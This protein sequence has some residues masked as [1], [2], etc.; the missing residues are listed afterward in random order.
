MQISFFR[1]T[2]Y[3]HC[4]T[5]LIPKVLIFCIYIYIQLMGSW[6]LREVRSFRWQFAT[7]RLTKRTF[8]LQETPVALADLK[9]ILLLFL[10][11]YLIFLHPRIIV[12]LIGV[13]L[14]LWHWQ[15]AN[16]GVSN[17]LEKM[18]LFRKLHAATK[19]ILIGQTYSSEYLITH[20]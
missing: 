18:L 19:L 15:H 13:T 11:R 1:L 5:L 12:L 7:A 2:R 6:S 3:M 20:L 9:L 8:N 17:F 14:N 10:L 16:E 4:I